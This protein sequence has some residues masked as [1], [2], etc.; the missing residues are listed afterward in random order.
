MSGYIFRSRTEVT[1]VTIRWRP[2]GVAPE[3]RL[4]W[5]RT[6]RVAG[7]PDRQE[8]TG[9]PFHELTGCFMCVAANTPGPRWCLA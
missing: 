5:S 7:R 6:R 9:T 4:E 8:S 2:I 3:R 1:V